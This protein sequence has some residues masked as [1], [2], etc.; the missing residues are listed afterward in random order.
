MQLRA[1]CRAGAAV[2]NM[3]KRTAVSGNENNDECVI[4]AVRQSLH[5][6]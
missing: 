1:I 5:R 6:A 2:R 4:I 3:Q